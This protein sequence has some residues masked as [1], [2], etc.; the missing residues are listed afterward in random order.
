MYDPST[1]MR[2]SQKIPPAVISAPT[3]MIGRV[4][5]RARSWEAIPA[6]TT[7]TSVCGRY[8]RPVRSAE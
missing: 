7:A 4:P 8:A 1:G 2:E 6:P 3:S 5:T